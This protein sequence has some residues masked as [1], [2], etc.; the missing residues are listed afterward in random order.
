M[1][2]YIKVFIALTFLVFPLMSQACSMY[3]LT[4]NG[5]TIVGNNEDYFTPNT[6]FWYEGG[7]AEKMGVMYMGFLD[8]FAQGAIN[9]GGLV[10]DG[11][12]EPYLEV[13]NTEGKLD[14]PIA[15]VIRNIMQTMVTVEEVKTYIQTVNLSSLTGSQIVFVD[16]SGT[17]LIVEGD[18]MFIGEESEKTF[19]NFYYSQVTSVD[20]V[21]IDYFQ[22]GQK[23]LS[24]TDV[25]ANFDYCGEAMKSFSQANLAP[26]QYSTIYDLN[27]LKIRV[28]LFHDYS[29]YV[30]ID[31]KEELKKGNHK[32]MIPELFSEKSLGYQHYLKYNNPEHPTLFI[33]EM[34]G[35]TQISEEE[36]N[37]MGFENIL[38]PIGYEWLDDL[39]NA[40]GAINVFEYGISLMPN[41]SNLHYGLGEAYFAAENWKESINHFAQSLILNPERED[42]VDMISEGQKA[43][44]LEK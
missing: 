36:F 12:Y 42:A 40:K 25:K 5:V 3:K 39:E 19:S 15:E 8:N 35:D 4:K 7:D 34:I 22:N 37:A 9:E 31:L 44:K 28:Y 17:Y 41:N 33:E 2:T 29:D 14:I 20:E 27:S 6:Q 30:E 26:T 24:E 32:T 43:M 10:F 11:F 1:K 23:F 16:K 18:E 13:N 21:Q 38:K